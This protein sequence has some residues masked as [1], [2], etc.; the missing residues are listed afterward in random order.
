MLI[1]PK[2]LA[3]NNRFVL[4]LAHVYTKLFNII[5][6]VGA[7]FF[8]VFAVLFTFVLSKSTI[9]AGRYVGIAFFPVYVVV[10]TLGIFAHRFIS[11]TYD[12]MFSLYP[13]EPKEA[14]QPTIARDC[15]V[16]LILGSLS[17]SV[18]TCV[19]ALLW[20]YAIV[21]DQDILFRKTLQKVLIGFAIVGT[22]IGAVLLIMGVGM[23]VA[24]GKK[25]IPMGVQNLA[26][27]CYLFGMYLAQLIVGLRMVRA[28][29]NTAELN[30]RLAQGIVQ[31]V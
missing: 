28:R 10:L 14:S 21:H 7:Q 29:A 24:G 22:A 11:R 31:Q 25:M 18:P 1:S 30:T 13:P 16:L 9:G 27:G 3:Q 5:F 17:F 8:L 4:I 19:C 20:L 26:F 2:L 23:L 12:A 6:L 15:A